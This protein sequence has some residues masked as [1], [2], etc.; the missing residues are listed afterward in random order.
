M[1]FSINAKH[2]IA[3]LGGE[4]KFEGM[5]FKNF[6]TLSS[7]FADFKNCV[8]EDC[9]KVELSKNSAEGCIFRNVSEISGHYTDFCGCTF[10]Q[11][12]S[13]GPL[14]SIENDGNVNGSPLTQLLP[15]AVTKLISNIFSTCAIF[16]ATPTK[17]SSCTIS[18]P[19]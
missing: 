8:F 14:L 10:V 6:P 11:C 12:C 3:F 17:I 19:F 5:T 13:Q 9:Q 2:G 15:L 1:G 7:E 16:R 18:P 4:E